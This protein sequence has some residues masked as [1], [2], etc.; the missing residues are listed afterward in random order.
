MNGSKHKNSYMA[1]NVGK[2]RQKGQKR[3]VHRFVYQFHNGIVP[4]GK[5]IDHINDIRDDNRLKNLQ[6]ITNKDNS[7]KSAKKHGYKFAS[8]SHMNKVCESH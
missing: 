2:Y 4:D 8:N 3:Y 5:V 6:L 1:C 7:K